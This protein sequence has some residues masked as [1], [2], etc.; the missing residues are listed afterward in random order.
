MAKMYPGPF[1][2]DWR[3]CASLALRSATTLDLS[4]GTRTV[5][6]P[7]HARASGVCQEMVFKLLPK[8]VLQHLPRPT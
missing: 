4:A 3:A 5:A 1:A 8:N 7:A 2:Q 6:R